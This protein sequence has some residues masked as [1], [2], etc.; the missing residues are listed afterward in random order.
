MSLVEFMMESH[1]VNARV[2]LGLWHSVNL[3]EGRRFKSTKQHNF[4]SIPAKK[5]LTFLPRNL[6]TPRILTSSR[7]PKKKERVSVW[8]QKAIIPQR[9]KL[10]PSV[11]TTS[12]PAAIKNAQITLWN[13]TNQNSLWMGRS[14]FP[15]FCSSSQ[16]KVSMWMVQ[17]HWPVW[18][19]NSS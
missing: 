10:Y 8:I 14:L 12:V 5:L 1:S 11:I 17:G 2:R 9:L 19:R 7:S 15:S 6:T 3:A 18:S 16:Y 4:H 13:I